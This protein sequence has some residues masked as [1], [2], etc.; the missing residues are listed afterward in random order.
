MKNFFEKFIYPT[1]SILAIT[2]S[3]LVIYTFS[4]IDL[5]KISELT[6]SSEIIIVFSNRV[7]PLDSSFLNKRVYVFADNIGGNTTSSWRTQFFFN[8]NIEITNYDKHNLVTLLSKG[9]YSYIGNKNIYPLKNTSAYN[10]VFKNSPDAIGW[11]DFDILKE[12]SQDKQFL[13]AI[14]ITEGVRTTP[15]IMNIYYNFKEQKFKT[16][17][18]EYNENIF[19][20]LKEY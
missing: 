6:S 9:I 12:L 10:A 16:V 17:I 1:T 4:Q 14:V 18:V 11:F 19:S 20:E 8:T 7:P 3:I 5:K 2:V 15:K 13:V